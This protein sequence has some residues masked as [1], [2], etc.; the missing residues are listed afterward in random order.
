MD[1]TIKYYIQK[2]THVSL[3]NKGQTCQ[4][5]FLR[6]LKYWGEEDLQKS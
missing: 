5:K 3:E 2:E 4:R 6:I 1:A